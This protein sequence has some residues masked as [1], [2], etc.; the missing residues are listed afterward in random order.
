MKMKLNPKIIL[1]LV[2]LSYIGFIITNLMTLCF[3]FELG[4]KANT[5]ISLFSD[6][7]FLIYLWSKDNQNEQ[8]H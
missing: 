7:F 2:T 8:K 5:V 6:I 1:I 3:D 4:V